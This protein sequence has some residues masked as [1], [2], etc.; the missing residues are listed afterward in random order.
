MAFLFLATRSEHG[1]HRLPDRVSSMYDRGQNIISE[2][3]N[4]DSNRRTLLPNSRKVYVP[5][6]LH[7][8]V[9]VPFREISL[10]PTKTMSGEIEVNE[11]V[12]VYDTSGP[13]GDADSHGDVERRLAAVARQMDSRP[14]RRGR[15]RRP[16]GDADRRRIPLRDAC[17]AARNGQTRNHLDR[18]RQPQVQ[19][20]DPCA[21]SPATP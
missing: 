14:R 12:R 15:N 20:A 1:F 4:P 10:A 8:D 11:P 3:E 17:R 16:R 18:L 5:G 2:P 19:R 7:P 21:P 9:R 13:W 6:Q